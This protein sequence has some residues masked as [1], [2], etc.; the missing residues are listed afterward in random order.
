MSEG[1]TK[2]GYAIKTL[3]IRWEEAKE[4]WQDS[5]REDFEKHHLIPLEKQAASTALGM[6]KL[7]E[8]LAK[9][10]QECS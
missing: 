7:A 6:D 5:V 9:A 1:S 3:R 4:G 2:L 10:R 8:V